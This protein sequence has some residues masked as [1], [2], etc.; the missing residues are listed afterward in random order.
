M[1]Y[2]LLQ[3]VDSDMYVWGGYCAAVGLLFSVLKFVN[4]SLHHMYD[5]TE[6]IIEEDEDDRTEAERRRQPLHKNSRRFKIKFYIGARFSFRY[7]KHKSKLIKTFYRPKI[8][9]TFA[10][11]WCIL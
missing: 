7:C 9:S 6:C 1:L 8:L 5:T 4:M 2:N 3:Y 10:N 11:M